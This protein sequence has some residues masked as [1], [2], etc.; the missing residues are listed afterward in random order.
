MKWN[1]SRPRTC[2]KC[3]ATW[4]EFLESHPETECVLNVKDLIR[5]LCKELALS[6]E[7]KK[8]TKK[9]LARARKILES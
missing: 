8:E 6:G 2:P 9:L 4:N 1:T 7:N 3:G 5:D